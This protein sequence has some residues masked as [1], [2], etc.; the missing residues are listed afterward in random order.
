M[1]GF[2]GFTSCNILLYTNI[3]KEHTDSIF[4]AEVRSPGGPLFAVD[5]DIVSSALLV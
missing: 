2:W 4:R 1:G 3:S 5:L